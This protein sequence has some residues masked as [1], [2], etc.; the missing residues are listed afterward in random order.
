MY[1]DNVAEVNPINELNAYPNP[2]TADQGFNISVSMDCNADINFLNLAGQS[3]KNT[4]K[5]LT[6]GYNEIETNDLESGVYFCTIS[7]NG[8]TTTTKIVI[9]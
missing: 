7:S 6:A 3:V 5:N 4:N 1:Y 9:R 8:Y 2:T